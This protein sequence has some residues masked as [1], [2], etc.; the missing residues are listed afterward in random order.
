M[1]RFLESRD[2]YEVGDHLKRQTG[3]WTEANPDPESRADAAYDLDKVLRFIDNVDDST[4]NHSENRNGKIDG[5][6]NYGYRTLDNSKPAC[7][8][9]FPT[10][11]MRCCAIYRPER[12]CLNARHPNPKKC[13]WHTKPCPTTTR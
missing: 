8:K 12:A 1:R 13:L 2:H 6:Y 5:F 3:D 4:L 9:R 10:T 7:S 11:V